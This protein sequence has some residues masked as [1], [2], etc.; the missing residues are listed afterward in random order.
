MKIMLRILHKF[1]SS[2]NPSLLNLYKSD[3][4]VPATSTSLGHQSFSA[5]H[6]KK[7]HENPKPYTFIGPDHVDS[8]AGPPYFFNKRQMCGSIAGPP[9]FFNER[10]MCGSIAVTSFSLKWFSDQTKA[11]DTF[12]HPDGSCFMVAHYKTH[13]VAL[14]HRLETFPLSHN[15]I[16]T[17]PIKIIQVA[18]A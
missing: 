9:Y 1:K 10:Q 17:D 13:F 12:L 2:I 11:H 8:I 16:K 15:K 6:R 5:A 4:W 7:N 14:L 3:G 18:S